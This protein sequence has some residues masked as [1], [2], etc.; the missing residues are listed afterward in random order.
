M[1]MDFCLVWRSLYYCVV[2][3]G[4][5]CTFS[6]RHSY[7]VVCFYPYTLSQLWPGWHS[8]IRLWQSTNGRSQCNGTP[9]S[10]PREAYLAF[11][12]VVI[13]AIQLERISNQT[14][15]FW[16]SI[17]KRWLCT[18]NKNAF[19]TRND[20]NRKLSINS[21]PGIKVPHRYFRGGIYRTVGQTVI[22]HL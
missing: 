8:L 3:L 18:G 13:E 21:E 1:R 14:F 5:I 10:Q 15:N 2:S 9:A 22:I 19:Q 20:R 6:K 7:I 16:H 17:P 12:I 11:P 4:L